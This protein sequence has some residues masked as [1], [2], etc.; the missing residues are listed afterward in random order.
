MKGARGL[1][2]W[3]L[4]LPWRD[5]FF[6]SVALAMIAFTFGGFGGA[7]NAAY[8]MNAMVHNTAWIHGH[9]HLTL[10][11]TVALSF[12]GATYWL[13]PR[14]RGRDL[15]FA[16]VARVQPYMWFAGMALFSISFHI[17]GVRGLPRRVFSA[18][19]GGEPVPA[20]QGLT[21]VAAVGG[22]IL[23]LSAL[24]FVV[25]VVATWLRGSQIVPPPFEFAVALRPPERAGLWDR[26]GMWTVVAVALVAL[27]YA[28]PLAS[29]LSHPRF[30]SPPF[31]PF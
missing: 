15:R 24:S 12:M 16:A 14:I 20:W 28:Y 6:S 7:I 25:V 21:R 5:P 26:L 27:A 18:S 31:Q 11:T 30:G 2:D 1:L 4:K 8:A 22:V 19:L 3:T 10:G 29:L 9:F 13:L 23:F 17:A